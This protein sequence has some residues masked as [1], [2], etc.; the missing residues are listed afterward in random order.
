MRTIRDEIYRSLEEAWM[1][2]TGY[3][4]YDIKVTDKGERYVLSENGR[5]YLKNIIDELLNK[6][7]KSNED[8][9]CSNDTASEK[10]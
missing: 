9:G 4:E 10:N 3:T 2:A 7:Y 6:P 1:D 8:I 5:V